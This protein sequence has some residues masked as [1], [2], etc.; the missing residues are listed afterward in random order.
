MLSLNLSDTGI[1]IDD[2]IAVEEQLVKF[3]ALE[4]LDLSHNEGLD[5][6]P[7]GIL[8]IAAR[9]KSFKCDGCTLGLPPQ[10]L[11]AEADKNPGVA[12]QIVDGT[13]DLSSL[14]SE[15]C[16]GINQE[17]DMRIWMEFLQIV[18]PI[19][20]HLDLS[21][22]IALGGTGVVKILTLFAGM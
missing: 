5:F 8:R 22:N 9:L 12:Q 4:H 1:V 21:H 16:E 7:L 17:Q 11:F 3:T 15:F 2:V 19:A 13:V 14:E 18:Y 20:K 10:R 6:L